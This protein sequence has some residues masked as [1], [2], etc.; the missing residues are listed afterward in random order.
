VFLPSNRTLGEYHPTAAPERA[1]V[2]VRADVAQSLKDFKPQAAEAQAEAF[3]AS[4]ANIDARTRWSRL[5]SGMQIALLPKSTRGQAVKANLTLRFGTE[6]RWP[7][8]MSYP[9][10]SPPCWTRAPHA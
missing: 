9:M 3:D 1:P 10:R 6:R 4:P 8:G 7:T 2:P 5:P